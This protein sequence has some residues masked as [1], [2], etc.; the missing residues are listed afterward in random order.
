[1]TVLKGVA[2]DDEACQ[3][4]AD[5]INLSQCDFVELK[6]AT[7]SP[8]WDKSN[9][10][11]SRDS[12]PRH[13]DVLQ[14]ARRLV[15]KLPMY[16]GSPS[17]RGLYENGGPLRQTPNSRIPLQYRDP[18]KIPPISETTTT[19]SVVEIRPSV[20]APPTSRYGIAAEHEH[21][22]CVLLGRR[23]RFYDPFG[24][25]RTW[26]DFDKLL[27]QISLSTLHLPPLFAPSPAPS[28]LRPPPGP[29]PKNKQQR[30]QSLNKD[31][32][33][34]RQEVCRRRRTRRDTRAARFCR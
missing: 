32:A 3:G 14:L 17:T 13:D 9:S 15:S 21:S 4:Y 10:G 27:I 30:K 23:D 2:A 29:L 16:L 22:F 24:H 7:F 8:V 25:W 28:P 12:I 1:M 6:A 26:I 19:D 18:N 31:H 11:L 5:L 34:H 33:S 20:S